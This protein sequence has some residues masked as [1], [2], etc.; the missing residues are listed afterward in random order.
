LTSFTFSASSSEPSL[1]A[2]VSPSR[3]RAAAAAAPRIISRV[4]VARSS[5]RRTRDDR[6]SE[7]TELPRRSDLASVDD[8]GWTTPPLEKDSFCGA[9]R[10]PAADARTAREKHARTM[11]NDDTE[12]SRSRGRRCVDAVGVGL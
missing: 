1:D 7:T 11:E 6:S 5:P 4:L 10:H 2:A 12:R 9:T 8:D 3:A